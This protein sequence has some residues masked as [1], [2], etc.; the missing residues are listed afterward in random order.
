MQPS[1][2]FPAHAGPVPP[3]RARRALLLGGSLLL[4]GSL[5]LG[6][7]AGTPQQA[8]GSGA[9]SWTQ[10]PSAPVAPRTGAVAAWTGSEALFLGGDVG[11][12][13][14]DTGADCELPP[15]ARDGAAFDPAAGT[16]RRTADAPVPVQAW[17]PGAVSGDTVYLLASGRLLSYDASDDAWTTHPPPSGAPEDGRLAVVDGLVVLVASERRQG[18]PSG[19]VY[20]PTKRSWSLLPEDPLGDAFDRVPTATSSGLVLTAHPLVPD[21]NGEEPSLVRAAVLDPASSR[22][23]HLGNSEQIGGWQWAWTGRRMVDPTLGSA[24]GGTEHDWGRD[25]P[26][27]GALDP[28]TGTWSSLRDAPGIGTDADDWPVEALGGPLSAVSGWVY[29]DRV[30]SWTS[31]SRPRGAPPEPGSAVWAGEQLIVLGGT[32]PARGRT[33]EA[34]SD[35]AW[36]WSPSSSDGPER[37]AAEAD[38]AG[39]WSLV[40]GTSGDEP[41]LLPEQARATI[42]FSAGS[43]V[44]G[45]S[46]CNG[47]GGRYE[48][49]GG[50]L[51]L[52]DIA[53]T[54]MGCAGPVGA[55]EGAYLDVLLTG[56]LQA[57][58]EGDRLVLG[59]DRGTLT[60]HRLPPVPTTELVGTRWVLESRVEGRTASAAVGEPA[61]L[62][63]REDGSFTASTGCR[64]LEGSWQATGDSVL[65][66]DYAY[67]T[68][69]CAPPLERQDLQL[70]AALGQGFQVS[71]EGDVLTLGDVDSRGAEDVSFVYRAR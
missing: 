32:D 12:P 53:S 6:A 15:G 40:E 62:E 44:G 56:P 33:V 18:E 17:L 30:Q 26:M 68:V 2:T 8:G 54:A 29:D 13:C 66:G 14:L 42:E 21:P 20:D 50:V 4:S 38:L 69:G 19:H 47:Y 28:A 25:I 57:G 31:L 46:F 55:A 43:R 58:V 5:L 7:C 16:W 41:L 9:G 1:A 70:T 37:N 35:G 52:Q 11:P 39:G 22:W 65:L 60:F 23:S 61:V 48:L 67:D 64:T 49:D 59:G 71:I 24:D 36:S 51:R 63:L 45:T 34:L 10:L 27:G 3:G